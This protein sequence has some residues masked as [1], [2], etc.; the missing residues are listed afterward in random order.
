[1]KYYALVAFFCLFC[2]HSESVLNVPS[3]YVNPGSIICPEY[4][5]RQVDA[6][7]V[8]CD[9]VIGHRLVCLAWNRSTCEP[10]PMGKYLAM[11][12]TIRTCAACPKGSF[13]NIAGSAS[14]TPCPYLTYADVA[15]S[16]TCLPCQTCSTVGKFRY[17]CNATYSGTCAQCTHIPTV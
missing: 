9:S 16:T 3:E 1:M 13:S 14:C 4:N 5:Y 7:C 8:S 15:G 2:I 12:G 6:S 10:C 11:N 17:G